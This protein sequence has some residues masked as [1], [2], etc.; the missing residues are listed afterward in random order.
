M[1]Y[2]V[3]IVIPERKYYVE[4]LR[5]CEYLFFELCEIDDLNSPDTLKSHI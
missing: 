4:M 3:D 1:C 5:G 2:D